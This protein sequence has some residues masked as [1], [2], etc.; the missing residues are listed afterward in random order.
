MRGLRA[1]VPDGLGV[2]DAD[3]EDGGE[4]AGGG[5]E[6]GEEAKGGGLDTVDGHAGGGEGGLDDGVVLSFFHVCQRELGRVEEGKGEGAGWREMGWGVFLTVGK[7]W[8]CTRLPGAATSEFGTKE[9]VLFMVETLTTCVTTVPVAIAAG[10]VVLEPSV[11]MSA[12]DVALEGMPVAIIIALGLL[13]VM[14]A[15]RMTFGVTLVPIMT[16]GLLATLVP[17][18]RVGLLMVGVIREVVEDF[19]V[20]GM[21]IIME[22]DVLFAVVGIGIVV[23]VVAFVVVPAITITDVLFAIGSRSVEAFGSISADAIG[24]ICAQTRTLSTAR[25]VRDIGKCI[26]AR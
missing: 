23:V 25:A 10:R 19:D 18:I 15:G 14:P 7:N 4:G 13:V 16:A 17:R 12:V 11:I 24:S 20:V 9:R 2:G 3:G 8:N 21:S 22:V 6:A 1:V 5:H 26:A